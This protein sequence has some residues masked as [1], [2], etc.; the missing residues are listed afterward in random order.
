MIFLQKKIAGNVELNWITASETNSEG[1]E[2]EHSSDGQSWRNLGFVEGTGFSSEVQNYSFFHQ[3]PAKGVHYY[4]LKQIDYD[5]AFEYSDIVS[6]Q[7]AVDSR[8]LAVFPNP[9]Q[10]GELTISL[11]ET[12]LESA[13]LRFFDRIGRKVVSQTIY[14][15]ETKLN[16][17]HLPKGLY[18]VVVNLEG[19]RF[20]E[21]VMIE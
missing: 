19:K 3:N 8:Q 2:I 14:G 9:V 11:P 5:G 7:F 15:T 21:K 16:V 18:L 20:S 4:R 17:Q 13:Y 1:F 12:E 6:V 10:S